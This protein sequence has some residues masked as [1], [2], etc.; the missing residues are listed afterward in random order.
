MN[1]INTNQIKLWLYSK[2]KYIEFLSEK[3][4][5]FLKDLNEFKKKQYS[6]S[7]SSLRQALSILFDIKPLEIAINAPPNKKPIL[8][9]NLGFISISH[10]ID[11]LLIGWSSMPIGID[12]ENSNRII[13]NNK[14]FKKILH[15]SELKKTNFQNKDDELK[16]LIK[17]WVIKEA[18]I[19]ETGQSLIKDGKEWEWINNKKVALNKKDNKIVKVFQE[20]IH[21]WEIGLACNALEKV[22]P[23]I[24]FDNT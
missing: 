20:N 2:D 18:I 23:I 5:S 21:G 10:C 11:A 12:I 15:T 13:K 8:E 17:I 1:S 14:I 4:K 6:Y 19:K 3:E 22:L 24:C 9:N 7:R 16:R